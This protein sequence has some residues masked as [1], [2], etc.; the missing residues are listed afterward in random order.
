MANHDEAILRSRRLRP[1]APFPLLHQ[2]LRIALYDEYAARAFH[3]LVVQAFGPLPPFATILRADEQHVAS[4]GRLCGRYG[5][6]RPADPFPAETVISPTWRGNLE[7]AMAGEMAKIRLYQYLLSQVPAQDLRQAFS[8]LQAASR[9]QHLPAFGQALEAALAREQSHA[10]R[11]VPADQAYV[12][13]GPLGTLFEQGLALLARQ[14]SAFG[15][16][17]GLVRAAHPALLGG[18]LAGG[19][20]THYLRARSRQSHS[21]EE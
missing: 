19:F 17:G 9:N 8:R 11:G 14:H 15:I 2:A 20:A 13:H 5:V 6:P 16:A 1:A 12:R 4:L 21:T 18:L 7:R 3:A 10:A